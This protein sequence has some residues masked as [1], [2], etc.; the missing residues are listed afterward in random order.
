MAVEEPIPEVQKKAS[1]Q[2]PYI[3]VFA[4]LFLISLG[5]LSW[6]LDVYNKTH[7]CN[8]YPDYWCDDR[9]TCNTACPADNVANSCFKN[10][11]TTGLASCLYGVASTT[12]QLCFDT[13][14]VTT[15]DDPICDCVKPLD[16]ANVQNCFAGCPEDLDNTKGIVCCCKEGPNCTPENTLCVNGQ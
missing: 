2:L 5:V 9:W 16:D 3:I 6:V 1:N 13:T 7:Q 10:L 11:T 12:A 8:L 15:H 14:D 4:I